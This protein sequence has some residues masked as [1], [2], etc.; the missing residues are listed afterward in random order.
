MLLLKV[1][2]VSFY[3]GTV[4][5]MSVGILIHSC[6]AVFWQAACHLADG[7]FF[8]FMAKQKTQSGIGKEKC[9][10]PSS[11]YNMAGTVFFCVCA[12]PITM[13]SLSMPRAPRHYE[14]K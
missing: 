3:N 2:W 6:C 5:L 13:V 7:H 1:S 14:D 11:I 8:F 4:T 9:D 10:N 12:A